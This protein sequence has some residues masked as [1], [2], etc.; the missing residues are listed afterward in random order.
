MATA[1]RTATSTR[2]H[3]K[4]SRAF[5]ALA[6]LVPILLVIG[7]FGVGAVAANVLTTPERHFTASRSPTQF[8]LA[9]QDVHFAARDDRVSIAGWYIPHGRT[10]RA[11]VL[12]HG[13]DGSR[14][15]EFDGKFVE[16]ASALNQHGYAVLMIDLRGHGQSGDAHFSFGLYERRDVEGAV[17]WLKQQGFQAGHIGVLGVSLGAASSIGATADDADIG[18]LVEDSG[19]AAILPIIQKE[20]RKASGLPDFMLTPTTIMA[21]IMFG[22]DPS[23]S[24]PVDEMGRIAPRPVL[25][26]HG[27]GDQLI[28]I[29]DADQLKAALP[30]AETWIVPDVDHAGAYTRDPQAYD[31]KVIEFFDKGLK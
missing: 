26:I 14:T 12:V 16:L 2:S 5:K 21:R 27:T 15:E 1:T 11:I 22:Y 28:P 25:I 29:S 9:Y 30:S 17:D 13:K 4:V 3:G 7:Y 10:Q 8:N 18:A 31:Q 20:W 24:R 6:I 23:T 19:Y